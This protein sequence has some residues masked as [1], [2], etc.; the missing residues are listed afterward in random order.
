MT[1]WTRSEDAALRAVYACWGSDWKQHVFSTN[2]LDNRS[3]RQCTSRLKNMKF[4]G[5]EKGARIGLPDPADPAAS[6]VKRI[7]W[8]QPGVILFHDDPRAL[9][10]SVTVRYLAPTIRELSPRSSLYANAGARAR[11]AAFPR[12][13][14]GQ[15]GSLY[16]RK[17][18][19]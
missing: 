12:E 6:K 18:A 13:V 1:S 10:D 17:A 11:N 5:L 19:Q 4:Y 7:P 9:E 15:R 3:I 8:P 14:P 2:D 16:A